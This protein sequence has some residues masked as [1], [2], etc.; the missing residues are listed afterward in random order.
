[1]PVSLKDIR[2]AHRRIA[3]GVVRTPCLEAIP[4]SELT[5]SRIFCKL[6]NQ[7]RTG[8]FKERGARNA[9][10]QLS[11][12][13]KQ[14][15]VIAASAGNHASAL[16]Y[17]GKLLG[18]PVTV[19][20]PASAPLIKVSTCERLGAR[21][22]VG[23]DDFAAA[24][25]RADELVE[26]EGLT[27]ING[28]DDPAIIAGQGTMG[29]EILDQVPDVEAIVVPIG[30]GGLIAGVATAVKARRPDV[31]IIGVESTHTASYSA[32]LRAGTPITV[33]SRPTLADGLAIAQVGA[34]A[35][36]L[37]KDRVDQV[38]T[39]PEDLI[40][41][42]ILRLLELQK[43][44]VEGA[45]ASTLA[46]MLSGKLPELKG[47]R[48]VLCICG[49]NI[50]PLVLSRIIEKG[51]VADGRRCRFTAVIS[52][53]P[54]GL[55]KLTQVIANS[56][57]SVTDIVHERAFSGPDVSKVHAVCTVET[58]DRQ[59]QRQLLRALTRAGFSVHR[60]EHV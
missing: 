29:L 42:S 28:Y 18:I 31:R 19:A 52:D 53:R 20:M 13:Q 24:R 11:D 5:G 17:H 4:L 43:D 60:S 38:V 44:V 46:A 6:D 49:G 48:V 23:G 16:A 2:N 35:F 8:S 56:G 39:V 54:G 58:R 51:L 3:D 7:Q 59:H 36:A 12:E 41:L 25:A 1:M 50:D 57:A 32:A 40:A 22:L 9:L 14:R 15:G 55:V 21:V 47:R 34:N 10:L 27:Y 33:R 30:G 45:A 37:A 26:S